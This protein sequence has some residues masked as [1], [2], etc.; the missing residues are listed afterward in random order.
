M[1]LPEKA[2]DTFIQRYF[3][4]LATDDGAFGLH[5][6]AASISVPDHQDLIV[7]TDTL[8]ADVHFFAEDP[9]AKIAQKALRVNLSDIAAKGARP[10]GYFLNL[11]L[12][13]AFMR[14]DEWMSEFS[15]GLQQDQSEFNVHLMGGDTVR[16][17]NTGVITICAYGVVPTG[18]MVRRNG[19]EAGD[20]LYVTGTIGDAALGLLMRKAKLHGLDTIDQDIGDAIRALDPQIKRHTEDRY[21][22]PQPRTGISSALLAHASAAMDVSDGLVGDARTLAN[23]SS[24]ALKIHT[25]QIPYSTGLEIL[26]DESILQRICLTGGDD[27]EILCTVPAGQCASFEDS[28]VAAN[29]AVAHIGHVKSGS[30][31]EVIGN[32][33][34][35]LSFSQSSYDHFS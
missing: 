8:V 13:D 21:L 4:R 32:D 28:A 17:A 7:S 34:K 27:Y 22:L 18:Q 20:R 10:V 3:A 5:D 25:D 11:T 12:P 1:N 9:P 23:A 24:V 19:A 35:E 29:I 14:S 2:E 30:G 15:H 26:S 16:C 31:V 6:D 33:G